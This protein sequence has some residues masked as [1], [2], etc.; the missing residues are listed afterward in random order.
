MQADSSL[1]EPP[2]KVWVSNSGL[3]VWSYVTLGTW[4]HFPELAPSSLN[5]CCRNLFY[6]VVR[7]HD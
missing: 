3:T 5:D 1:S 7:N 6:T 2:G 4:L